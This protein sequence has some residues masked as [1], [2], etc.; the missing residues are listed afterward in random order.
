MSHADRRRRFIPAYF[1]IGGMAGGLYVLAVLEQLTEFAPTNGWFQSWLGFF[2]APILA[3]VGSVILLWDLTKPQRFWRLFTQCKGTSAV[4]IGSWT[5]L[6]F[7]AAATVAHPWFLQRFPG[8]SE[9]RTFSLWDPLP[10][11]TGV[12]KITADTVREFMTQTLPHPAIHSVGFVAGLVLISYTGWL[13]TASGRAGWNATPWLGGIF[14]LLAIQGA[15][16][17]T[18]LVAVWWSPS[19]VHGVGEGATIANQLQWPTLQS[20]P[21]LLA[22]SAALILGL[23]ALHLRKMPREWGRSGARLVTGKLGIWFRVGL[24]TAGLIPQ[25]FWA[26]SGVPMIIVPWICGASL[27]G[28]LSL[29]Y[30]IFCCVEE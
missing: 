16:A 24:V 2:W 30:T 14:F 21:K 17:V 22:A 18:L 23:I 27:V 12:P 20:Y 26:G 29:R 15:M 19:E 28:N 11:A 5:L 9:V 4:S 25:T 1:F 13:L 7:G 10:L 8:L 3:V 6:I